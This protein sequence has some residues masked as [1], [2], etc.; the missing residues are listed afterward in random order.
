MYVLR[1]QKIIST[2]TNTNVHVP[3]IVPCLV[4]SGAYSAQ[5]PLS[6]L[7]SRVVLGHSSECCFADDASLPTMLSAG[8]RS[9]LK[10]GRL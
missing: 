10:N 7:E 3:V 4:R 8:K 9:R 2:H 6:A 5:I 1:R